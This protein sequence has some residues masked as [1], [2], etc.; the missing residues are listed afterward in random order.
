MTHLA[1]QEA[2]NGSSADWMEKVD[3]ETYDAP[4]D[5][6]LT[7]AQENEADAHRSHC[8]GHW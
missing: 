6:Q 7:E 4:V 8:R 5:E 3:D 2:E 1:L